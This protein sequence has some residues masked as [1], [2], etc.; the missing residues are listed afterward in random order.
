[1][2]VLGIHK[3]KRETKVYQLSVTLILHSHTLFFY[4]IMSAV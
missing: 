2:A 4:E 1:M 3:L